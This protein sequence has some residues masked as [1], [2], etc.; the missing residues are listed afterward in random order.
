LTLTACEQI[1][2]IDQC[3]SNLINTPLLDICAVYGDSCRKKC[4]EL[5]SSSC[6]TGGRGE[7][8]FWLVSDPSGLS[9]GCMNKVWCDV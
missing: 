9:G 6:E 5:E 3:N 8:C 2:N 1:V 4:E 7:D